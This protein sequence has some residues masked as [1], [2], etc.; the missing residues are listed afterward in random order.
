MTFRTA[1]IARLARSAHAAV[2]ETGTGATIYAATSKRGRYVVGG[3]VPARM[4]PIGEA[5]AALRAGARRM[6]ALPGADRAETLGY[7]EDRG[8]VY[9]DLGDTWDDL[10]SALAVATAR[11]ELAI[12]DTRTGQC[13]S[14]PAVAA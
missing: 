10:T 2:E 8:T 6:L 14:V 3:V 1:D 11:M 7:W 5:P 13:I 4:Y 12:Y 9:L